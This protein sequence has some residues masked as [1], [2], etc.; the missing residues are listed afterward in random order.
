MEVGSSLMNK[1]CRVLQRFGTFRSVSFRFTVA[2]KKKRESR[3]FFVDVKSK[4]KSC[5][6]SYRHSMIMSYD[7]RRHECRKQILE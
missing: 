1:S 3:F 7:T 4:F 5:G 2:Q 6:Q